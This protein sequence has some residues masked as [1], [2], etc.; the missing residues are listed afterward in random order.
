[1]SEY[2]GISRWRARI[3]ALPAWSSTLALQRKESA[4]AS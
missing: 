1:L 2:P 3:T 4:T